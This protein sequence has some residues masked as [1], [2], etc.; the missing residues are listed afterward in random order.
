MLDYKY[1]SI[2]SSVFEYVLFLPSHFFAGAIGAVGLPTSVNR[3]KVRSLLLAP[4]I[5]VF[6]VGNRKVC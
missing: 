1:L 5:G 2:Y 6:L 4:G 3:P